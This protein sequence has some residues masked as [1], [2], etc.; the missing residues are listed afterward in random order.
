MKENFWHQVGMSYARGMTVG[1]GEFRPLTDS[2]IKE[3]FSPYAASWTQFQA[4]S[5]E[6]RTKEVVSV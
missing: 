2:E 4:V 3:L 1:K 6:Y 5:S